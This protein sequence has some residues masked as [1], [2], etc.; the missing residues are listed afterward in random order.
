MTKIMDEDKQQKCNLIEYVMNANQQAKKARVNSSIQFTSFGWRG[1]GIWISGGLFSSL[2]SN[3]LSKE[4][5]DSEW[6]FWGSYSFS[7][8]EKLIKGTNIFTKF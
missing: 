1:V 4:S 3:K 8:Q 5:E 2:S 6:D 7:K